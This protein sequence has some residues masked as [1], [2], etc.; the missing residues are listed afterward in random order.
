MEVDPLTGAVL[1]R[2]TEIQIFPA[3]HFVTPEDRVQQAIVDIEEELEARLEELNEQEKLLEAQ[4][5]EQRT[6]YDLEMMREIGYCSGIENY[7]RH[8]AQ[9]EA[10]RAAL[11]ADRL[12]SRRLSDGHRRVAHDGA[13]GAGDVQ[14][15][16]QPQGD[17]GRLWLPPALSAWTTVR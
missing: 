5:L 4:R 12:L 2:P 14:R 8:L 10:G 15:G 11:D 7:S 3:K 16:P 13:A 9:R 1:D 17:A 6:R